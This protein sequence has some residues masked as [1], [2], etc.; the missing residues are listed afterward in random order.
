MTDYRAILRLYY[1]GISGRTI[2]TTL[3]CSRNTVSETLKRFEQAELPWPLPVG[4]SDRD[5]ANHLYPEHQVQSTTRKVPDYEAIHKEMA[6]PGVTLSLLWKE[7]C[8]VCRIS[9]EIPYMYTQFCKQYRDYASVAK[10]TMHIHRKPGEQMEVDWAGQTGRL[11]DRD[12]GELTEVYIFIAALP[13]SQYAYVEA[14][15][16][17]N[18]ENWISAHVN[19]YRYFGGVTRILIPDN[20]K[21]GV[22]KAS[23]YTPVINNTYHEMAEHYGTVVIPARVRKPKDKASVEGT[24]GNISTWIVAALRHQKFF[25][26]RE[27]NE[28]IW[29]KLNDF[30][31]RPFQKKPGSRFSVFTEEEKMTLLPLP[32]KDYELATWKV[33][34]VQFN[35]HIAVDKMYYSVPFEYIKHKVDVRITRN[36]IEVFSDHQR[37]CSHPRLR[38]RE[39]QYSTRLEHMP[40]DHKKFTTWNAERFISWAQSIG[41]CTE[42][43]I[44][45]ILASHR[46]EQQGY[47]SCMACLKLAE[48]HGASR[49]EAACQKA[50]SY[51]PSPSFKSVQT[52]LKTQQ[53]KL[54]EEP[55]RDMES[56]YAFTRGADYYGRNS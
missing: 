9:R 21:T 31:R 52:I 36:I 13:C 40:E 2:A 50:L 37:I 46:V 22:D 39:G 41:T 1:Q 8:D 34:T 28:A 44:R 43:V 53:D 20:L 6:I 18:L 45:A 42:V 32:D 12:T 15:P 55:K 16:S 47:R 4:L 24:V 49:L 23:W 7:Y 56:D 33:A 5:L 26:V 51:T 54:P 27:M 35:Y 29:E 17:Q 30:N 19:A 3:G 14:S 10:A 11:I 25:T 48:K 38:G